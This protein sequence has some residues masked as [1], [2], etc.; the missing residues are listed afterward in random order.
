MTLIARHILSLAA[1][2]AVQ[3][4]ATRDRPETL[5]SAR[6]ADRVVSTHDVQCGE[7]TYRIGYRFGQG[8]GS[9]RGLNLTLLERLPVPIPG[10]LSSALAAEFS[11]F[12]NVIF[13]DFLC[14][15]TSL[16]EPAQ[17][18][19][20]EM[21]GSY[22]QDIREAYYRCRAKDWNFD[23]DT[24]RTFRIEETELLVD[25]DEIGYCYGDSS[26]FELDLDNDEME[27]E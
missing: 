6:G 4:C 8:Q 15:E 27:P 20:V 23:F 17:F 16:E 9:E 10:E 11:K 5:W 22:K 2:C 12:N 7:T 24:R 14:G 1:F 26:Y 21:R 19:A 25:D 18:L 3:G 13:I